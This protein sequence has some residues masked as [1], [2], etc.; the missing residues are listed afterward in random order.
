MNV[1]DNQHVFWC[2]IVGILELFHAE[3]NHKKKYL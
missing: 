1:I 2:N 3:H